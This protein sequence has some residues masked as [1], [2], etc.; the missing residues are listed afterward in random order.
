M[1]TLSLYLVKVLAWKIAPSHF[2]QLPQIQMV[3]TL[4]E[5]QGGLKGGPF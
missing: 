2:L 5:I 4:E 1:E 3:D